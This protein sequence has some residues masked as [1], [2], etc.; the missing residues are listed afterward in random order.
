MGDAYNAQETESEYVLTFLLIT[1]FA[2]QHKWTRKGMKM[3]KGKKRMEEVLRFEI[4]RY[5]AIAR[6]LQYHMVITGLHSLLLVIE[7]K[8]MKMGIT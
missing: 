2:M 3:R 4:C 6:P 8:M 7:A 1:I 5:Y